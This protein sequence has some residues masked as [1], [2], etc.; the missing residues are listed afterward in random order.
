MEIAA[1][2]ILFLNSGNYFVVGHIYSVLF[3]EWRR[4]GG[5]AVQKDLCESYC[6]GPKIGVISGSALVPSQ[7]IVNPTQETLLF[8]AMV[9]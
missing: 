8:I 2:R 4:F 6:V 1:K 9:H 3:G 7:C 5:L